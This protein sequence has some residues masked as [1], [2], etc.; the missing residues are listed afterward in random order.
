PNQYAEIIQDYAPTY[1]PDLIVVEMFV[2]DYL[3]ALTT[4]D[5]FQAS[6]GFGERSP[7]GL[8]GVLGLTHLRQFLRMQVREPLAALIK[9]R[10]EG[11]GYSLGNFTFLERDWPAWADGQRA[12]EA[13]LQQ[14]EGVAN[15]THTPVMIV[16]APAAPQVCA[17]RDL[18]YYPRNVDLSDTSRFDLD[19]PQRLTQSLAD[20]MQFTYVDLRPVLRQLP[21]GCPYQPSNMHWTVSGHRAV[22]DFLAARLAQTRLAGGS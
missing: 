3:D 15:Q 9:N 20:Q 5:A 1:Q 7:D 11:H 13:R 2:N 8:M 19:K 16:M 4:N 17:P 21:D 10:P 14:I 6:I 18:A 22:A 12:V